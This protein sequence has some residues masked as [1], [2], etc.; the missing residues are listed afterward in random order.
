[1]KI[2]RSYVEG[3]DRPLRVSPARVASEVHAVKAAHER[4]MRNF[5]GDGTE[6]RHE[7]VDPPA[8]PV[9]V[10][11]TVDEVE[12]TIIEQTVLACGGCITA[13]AVLLGRS[14]RCVHMKVTQYQ[15]VA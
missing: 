6:L 15:A 12:Q 5:Y 10:G 14:R 8:F 13:A 7:V 11:M 9:R 4:T 3:I 1:M 2:V